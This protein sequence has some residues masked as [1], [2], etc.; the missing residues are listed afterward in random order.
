M[1]VTAMITLPSKHAGLT[2]PCDS[3]FTDTI[4]SFLSNT[5]VA[6]SPLSHFIVLQQLWKN[7]LINTSSETR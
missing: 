6:F 4:Y 7:V 1:L 3:V 2:L 5:S